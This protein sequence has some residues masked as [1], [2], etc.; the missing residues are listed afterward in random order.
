MQSDGVI[1]DDEQAELDRLLVD[2]KVA[3]TRLEK[4]K[5]EFLLWVQKA[6]KEMKEAVYFQQRCEHEYA[7]YTEILKE[8]QSLE[9]EHPFSPSDIAPGLSVCRRLMAFGSDEDM[10][11][12]LAIRARHAGATPARTLRRLLYRDGTSYEGEWDTAANQPCGHG[13]ENLTECESQ[14]LGEFASDLRDGFGLLILHSLRLGFAGSWRAGLREGPGLLCS[15]TR[16]GNLIP[17]VYCLCEDDKS[18]LAQNP[19]PA[20]PH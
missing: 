18:R 17:V 2:V 15:F 19:C 14:Y 3:E 10:H 11:E 1:D 5:A 20:L 16:S 4:E 7:A 9:S 12:P 6:E 13:S 8:K